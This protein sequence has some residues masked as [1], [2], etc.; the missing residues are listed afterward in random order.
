MGK[1]RPK[2]VGI[3]IRI[4]TETKARWECRNTTRSG[5]GLKEREGS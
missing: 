2:P 5:P 4:S 1:A 3:W